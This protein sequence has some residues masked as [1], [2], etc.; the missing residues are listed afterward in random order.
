MPRVGVDSELGGT[1]QT[2]WTT[3]REH[4][5]CGNSDYAFLLKNKIALNKLPT[6]PRVGAA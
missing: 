5:P 4:A 2:S 1:T 3:F 6:L